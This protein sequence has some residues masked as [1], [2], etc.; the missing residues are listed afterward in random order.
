MPI[1]GHELIDVRGRS[2]YLTNPISHA[3]ETA[4]EHFQKSSLFQQELYRCAR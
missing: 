2:S 1:V 4:R 3:K